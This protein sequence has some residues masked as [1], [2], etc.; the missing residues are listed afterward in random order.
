MKKTQST[1]HRVRIISGYWKSRR[2]GIVDIDGLRPSTDRVRET[3]F[4][5]LNPYLPQA[6]VI[7]LFAG[8][9]ILGF[10]ACSRGAQEVHF[11]EKHP[12]V[13][14][15]L[16]ENY[17]KLQ[18]S[19]P[20]SSI[21]LIQLDAIGWLNNQIDLNVDVIFIDPPFDQEALLLQA[22]Q[23]IDRRIKRDKPPIIYVESSSK[24]DKNKILD[25]IPEWIIEKE[26]VAGAVRANVLRLHQ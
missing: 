11:I 8:T 24:L 12:I 9:G 7:D 16:Q 6:R 4:N 15:A 25:Q 19:P 14:K 18:P 21:H 20:Q 13:Y 3:V 26:L 23:L 2:I 5:W 10:E 1:A 17:S 22:L